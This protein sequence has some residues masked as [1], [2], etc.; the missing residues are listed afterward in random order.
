[1]G[2]TVVAAPSGDEVGVDSG[3]LSINRYLVV[4]QL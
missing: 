4:C 3:V 2:D 1:M